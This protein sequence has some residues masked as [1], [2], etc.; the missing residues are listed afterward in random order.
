MVVVQKLHLQR[1]GLSVINLEPLGRFLPKLA[2]RAFAHGGLFVVRIWVSPS[3]SAVPS[4]LRSSARRHVDHRRFIVHRAHPTIEM[5]SLP[6][7]LRKRKY[8][9]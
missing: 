9:A 4:T 5:V 1:D 2:R 8:H 7:A 3:A 6:R